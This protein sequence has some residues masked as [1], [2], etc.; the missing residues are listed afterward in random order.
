MIIDRNLDCFNRQKNNNRS[1]NYFVNWCEQNSVVDSFR[2]SCPEDRKYT[3]FRHNPSLIASKLDMIWIFHSLLQ[4]TG[5]TFFK[6]SYKTGHSLI[7][8]DCNCHTSV[9]GK[10]YYKY[11]ASLLR[12]VEYVN[13]TKQSALDIIEQSE[14]QNFHHRQTWE[15][16]K[17]MFR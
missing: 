7:G 2:F 17:V 4:C 3:W 1:H 9:Y 13:E 11:N 10:G 15:F 6:P 8:I 14:N 5:P 12:N 16:A